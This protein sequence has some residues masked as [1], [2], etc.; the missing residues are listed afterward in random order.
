M[1]ASIYASISNDG[2]IS[3]T[4]LVLV[5]DVLISVNDCVKK[6]RTSQIRQLIFW[7]FG[8]RCKIK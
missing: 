4:S 6:Y 5:S 1:R 7:D 3:F 2:G 8:S